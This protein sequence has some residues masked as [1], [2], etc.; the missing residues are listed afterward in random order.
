MKR[1]AA[2]HVGTLVATMAL[3]WL[4]TRVQAEEAV[5]CLNS[6]GVLAPDDWST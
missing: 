1:Q 2:W 6:A 3:P 5:I 4:G